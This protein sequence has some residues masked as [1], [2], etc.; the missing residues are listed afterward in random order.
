M[1]ELARILVPGG[2]AAISTL[3]KQSLHELRQSFHST[4]SQSHVANFPEL[5]AIKKWVSLSGLEIC[6]HNEKR[7]ILHYANIY[8]A[9]QSLRG[10]GAAYK[11]KARRKTFTSRSRFDAMEAT[12]EKH[13]K[14]AKGLPMTWDIAYLLLRKP[15]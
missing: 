13:F 10:V 12:Y 6:N 8:D 5:A 11:N 9:M 4:D 3:T 14:Q 15:K 2:Y 7:H 1:H